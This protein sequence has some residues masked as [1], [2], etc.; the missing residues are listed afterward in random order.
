MRDPQ[1]I[2]QL[3]SFLHTAHI[4][5][6]H[7]NYMNIHNTPGN[8]DPQAFFWNDLESFVCQRI[9]DGDQIILTG[10]FNSEF[11]EVRE[12]MLELGL[13]EGICEKHGY[14]A[15][16]NTYQRSKFFN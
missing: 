1:I 7:L 10:Y 6:Q 16:P 15:A 11:K 5:L 8:L 4:F 14:D 13:I 9:D 3:S 2:V 12:W